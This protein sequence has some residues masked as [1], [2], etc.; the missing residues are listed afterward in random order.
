MVIYKSF[1]FP[2][3]FKYDILLVF[4]MPKQILKRFYKPNII[5]ISL[6][7]VCLGLTFLLIVPILSHL[8]IIPC[9]IY[10]L[11]DTKVG[12]CAV[13]PLSEETHNNTLYFFSSFADQ[14]YL[15]IYFLMVVIVIPYTLACGVFQVYYRYIKRLIRR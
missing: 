14:I 9:K 10:E 11:P 13:N 5:N 15:F 2:E 12:L 4:P 6:A 1:D 8:K 3:N 7:V